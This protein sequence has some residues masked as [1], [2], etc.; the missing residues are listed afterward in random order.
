MLV[1]AYPCCGDSDDSCFAGVEH[2]AMRL[3]TE[4]IIEKDEY[5]HLVRQRNECFN[6][7]KMLVNEVQ[8]EWP[9]QDTL[10]VSLKIAVKVLERTALCIVNDAGKIIRVR[11]R[12]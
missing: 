10:P 4:M 12:K 9:N 7:L 8:D 5:L 3:I 2:L 6:A 1:R 11:E